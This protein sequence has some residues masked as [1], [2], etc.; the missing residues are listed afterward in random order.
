[1]AMTLKTGVEPA[2]PMAVDYVRASELL[3]VCPRTVWGMVKSGE[4]K[5][6][7]IGRSVR[8]PMTELERFLSERTATA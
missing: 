4:L 3:S 6:V 1:M 2:Q 5:A 8:I 7:R